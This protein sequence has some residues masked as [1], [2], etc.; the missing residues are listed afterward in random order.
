MANADVTESAP[1]SLSPNSN[2]APKPPTPAPIRSGSPAVATATPDKP[3]RIVARSGSILAS[4]AGLGTG[5]ASSKHKKFKGGVPLAI[6]AV[7][8][9]FVLIAMNLSGANVRLG[10]KT[11]K[12]LVANTPIAQGQG[13]SGMPGL[14]KD[15][16]MLFLFDTVQ[17]NCF[18][19]K[20]MKFNIDILWFDQ[21]E[22]LVHQERDV[23]PSTYPKTYCP[24]ELTRYVLEVPAGTSQQLDLHDSDRLE[25]NL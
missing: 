1:K 6:A 7:V 23:S 11:F 13:L 25:I 2:P 14:G 10:G 8:A 20:D 24:K 5:S 9:L 17:T 19:M 4:E 3:K 16:G 15:Q 12:V 21:N 22:K 18:W